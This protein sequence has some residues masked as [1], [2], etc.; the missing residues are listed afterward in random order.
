MTRS[1]CL[2]FVVLLLTFSGCQKKETEQVQSSLKPLQFFA[3]SDLN[4]LDSFF[5]VLFREYNFAYTLFGKKPMS[6]ACYWSSPVLFSMYNPAQFLHLEKGWR[7]WQQYS[8][9]FPSADFVLKKLKSDRF[10]SS[11]FLINKKE[12]LKVILENQEKFE[13]SLKQKIDPEK[14]LE[15]LC[16]SEGD[17][18]ALVNAELLGLLLGYG[19]VNAMFFERKADIFKHLNAKMNPPFTCQSE[20]EKLKPFGQEFLKLCRRRESKLDLAALPFLSQQDSLAEELNSI[21]SNEQIFEVYG[22]DFFLD[23]FISPVF[24]MRKDDPETEQLHKS[25]FATKLKLHRVYQQESFLETTLS[26][27]MCPQ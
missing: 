4:A 9:F 6:M 14:F 18:I 26:Q 8:S 12:V 10:V 27:W 25:Y 3:E 13:E 23:R 5:Q 11:I 7:L 16:D 2:V 24:V 1:F 15:Q 21:L 17:L 22:S 19:K 20:I